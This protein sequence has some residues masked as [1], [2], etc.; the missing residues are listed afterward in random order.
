MMKRALLLAFCLLLPLLAGCSREPPFSFSIRWGVSGP[1]SGSSY[2][3]ATGVLVKTT[4]ASDPSKYRAVL[5]LNRRE[6]EE[7]CRLAEQIDFFRIPQ[8]PEKY[9]PYAEREGE[10]RLWTKPSMFVEVSVTQDGSARTVRCVGIPPVLL[11]PPWET[12]EGDPVPQDE[13]GEK[14]ESF[15]RSALGMIFESEE[16]QSLSEYEILYQ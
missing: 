7:L 2:D 6:R 16:W 9:D 15:V 10:T 1:G 13:N 11:S 12:S 8:S 14:F 5:K 3:S 4:Q